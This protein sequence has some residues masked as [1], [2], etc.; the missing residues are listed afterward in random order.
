MSDNTKP[1]IKY[2]LFD[3]DGLLI[4]SEQVYTNVTNNILAPYGKVMTWDI[5]KELVCTPA[6][7]ASFY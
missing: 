2:V 6:Y 4:D 5:K 3:M 1:Q 7:L